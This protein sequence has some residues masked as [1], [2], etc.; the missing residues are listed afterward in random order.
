M[1]TAR[2]KV[3]ECKIGPA[4]AGELPSGA[5]G[6]MRA[7]I[8]KAFRGMTGRDADALFSGWGGEFNPAEKAVIENTEPDFDEVVA[9]E[10]NRLR[11][12]GLLDAVA[13]F[14]T[15]ESSTADAMSILSRAMTA[16]AE[17]RLGWH[18]NL[19]CMMQDEGVAKPRADNRADTFLKV[20]F[21]V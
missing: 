17:Y 2:V 21:G 14:A 5:D 15:R 16:D 3:W 13:A 6:P 20:A 18:A 10:A 12:R 4:M 11:E 9:Y 8:E 7:A 19:S 1:R